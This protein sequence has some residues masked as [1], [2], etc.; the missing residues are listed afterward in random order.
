[1]ETTGDKIRNMELTATLFGR[2]HSRTISSGRE[3]RV[4]TRIDSAYQALSS[5]G[6]KGALRVEKS[7]VAGAVHAAIVV[8]ANIAVDAAMDG[9]IEF[10]SGGTLTPLAIA[11]NTVVDD[12]V[13]VGVV[14]GWVA[15]RVIQDTP[16]VDVATNAINT[17]G[18]AVQ[19]FFSGW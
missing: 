10:A 8:S 14:A 9:F 11:L 15:D 2:P 18:N 12:G 16:V 13:G 1:M 19:S 7:V 4:P 3:S 17:V 6:D 5:A